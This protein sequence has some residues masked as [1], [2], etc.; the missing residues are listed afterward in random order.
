MANTTSTTS[1]RADI[2]QLKSAM[3]EAARQVKLANSEFKAATAK[4]DDWTK[5]AEGIRAKLKQL[6]TTL[7]AQK[8]QLE[9]YEK[10]LEATTKEYG[11]NSAA[12]DRVRI[13]TNNQKA[14][15]AKTEKQIDQY[16]D[17]LK[18]TEK[19]GDNF[20][21]T[22]DDM[23]DAAKRASDGFSVMKGAL[24]DLVADGIRKAI[25]GFKELY[26]QTI[27]VG[28]SF[29]SSMS[30]VGAISGANKDEL[31]ALTDKAKEMGEKTIF[32]ATESAEAFQYMAMAGWDV[33]DMLNGIEGI[34][35]LAAA[36][37]E[38]LATTSDIVTDALTAMG[39]SAG[40][41]GKLAD[42]MAA[43]SANANTNVGLMGETFQY[44]APIVGALGM[45]ME[46]TAVAVGL[47]ANAGIKG[48]KSGTALR[49]ILTRLSTD[50]GASSESLGALG[51]LTEELGVQFY[52]LDGTVRPLSDILTEARK[53]W[54][55]LSAEQQTSY[56]KTIAGQEAL[57]GWLALMNAADDDVNDLTAAVQNASYDIEDISG[58][59]ETSGVAWEKY[60]ENAWM[61]AG[62]G[63][64]GLADDI[65]Y[66]IEQVGTST[67][68]LKNYLMQE[69]DMNAGDAIKAIESVKTA[70]DDSSGAAER[71]A[72]TM[73][74]N[75]A[76]KMTLLRSKIEGIQI[77]VY[78]KLKPALS[79]AI[80]SFSKVLDSIDWD[81]VANGLAKATKAVLDFA[82]FVITNFTE[83]IEIAKSVG[84]VLLVTFAVN[85]I[86][87]FVSTVAGLI[88]TFK[89]LR[90]VTEG[91]TVAQKALNIAQ[92]ANVIGAITA[93][94][95]GL[96][97]AF[98]LFADTSDEAVQ[99]LDPLTESEKKHVEEVYAMRD[100]YAEVKQRRDEAVE[101]IEAEYN[102][103]QSLADEL[104]DLVDANGKV[105]EGYEDRVNFILTTLNEAVGTEMQLVD[106]VIENYQQEKATLDELIETKKAEA[107]LDA[108]KEAYTE[109]IK[110]RG[111]ALQN[112]IETQNDY[113]EKQKELNDLLDRQSELNNVSVEEYAKQTGA[114]DN[115]KLAEKQLW[116]EKQK[117]NKEIEAT[118]IGI[119]QLHLAT[120]TAEQTFV[121]FNS[122]IKNYEGLSSAIISGDTQKISDALKDM[123]NDFVTAETGTEQSLKN[124][125][126]AFKKKYDE[127]QKAVEEGSAVVTQEMVD[128][129][130]DMVDKSVKELDKFQADAEK[131][132]KQG[133]QKYVDGIESMTGAATQQAQN[134]RT[135]TAKTMGADTSG[136]EQAGKDAGQKYIEGMEGV[137][138]DILTTAEGIGSD[139]VDS[140]NEGQESHSPSAL[141]T[142]SGENFGQ[143]FING[144]D[145]KRG[146]IWEMA[147]SLARRAINALRAGQKEGSPSKLTYQSGVYFVQGYINGIASQQQN[148]QSAIQ[149]MVKGVFNQLKKTEAY[150]FQS[151]GNAAVQ[152]FSDSLTNRLDYTYSK[153]SYQNDKKVQELE[154]ALE[155]LQT[156][157]NTVL[158]AEETALDK[159]IASLEQTRANTL[160]H[161]KDLI[162]DSKTAEF[163]RQVYRN[164]YNQYKE[165][166]DDA[167]EKEKKNG[168]K[169][170]AQLSKQYAKEI[171][172][173]E[174][175][176]E[177]Y[178]TASQSFLAEYQN[179]V[180][181]YK[182]AAVDLIDS[183]INGLADKYNAQYDKL[184][185][186]QNSLVDKLKNAGTLFDVSG[187][188]IMT[189]ND[190]RE[191]TRQITEYTGKLQ[192]IKTKVSAELFDEI[193]SFDMKEGSAY[194]DRLLTMSAKDLTAY[195]KAYT[196]KLKAAEKAGDSIYKTDIA[197]V[198]KSYKN[199]INK[200]FEDMPKQLE[201]L[202]IQA[203]K[204]FVNGL[205][206]NTDYLGKS[207]TTFIKSM[208]DTFKKDL[209]IAS[210]SK[211]MMTIGDYTGEGF[212]EG[213]KATIGQVKKTAGDMIQA[214]ASPLGDVKASV[215]GVRGIVSA[216]TGAAAVNNNTV[217]NYNLVQNNT[218]PKSLSALETYQARRQ[219]IAMMKAFAQ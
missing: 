76:G 104:D 36:S 7:G 8:K 207:V 219:Q 216:G 141:T 160:S 87:T 138:P 201:D 74:D 3:Q 114:T 148:L 125:V 200:A 79:D 66:H 113:I 82:K 11:E 165:Y 173:Q 172:A 164:L 48:Q 22:A 58:A 192:K 102:N 119:G 27:N 31:D 45:N 64:E 88:T 178:K 60:A 101:S 55:G 39:Y 15:I 30:K 120:D 175:I 117:L 21:E 154:K 107:F 124:Q 109:A 163:M 182:N 81:S 84:K 177:A 214:A 38:D 212:V 44:A 180:N 105:K 197:A 161:Y 54:K 70:L 96:A 205:T 186:K 155:K 72:Q 86:A 1:F 40:D 121:N 78:E 147:Y 56:G 149:T 4:M 184:I 94:V 77:Q 18:E 196:E 167:I 131:S 85:K 91:A 128:D 143:G 110:N 99:H 103:Y 122:T 191:Q 2:S 25:S 5:S 211:V 10:E 195:N 218:S 140:L 89:T 202:G 189:V 215:G 159:R 62:K 57:S 135:E 19:A 83:I 63:I 137:K 132:G 166:Y 33:E 187:A 12:A 90:T 95:A 153:M 174:K 181:G 169:Y 59:L 50:A 198:S 24:A 126:E 43:A 23:T 129:M 206:N 108:N 6:D 61:T 170:I 92:S 115:L 152:S 193:A 65:A 16:N 151:V 217:N 171:A 168:E 118:K 9:L 199:E 150:N 139:A 116:V 179:A 37:G 194:I 14:A 75:V 26:K 185:D 52:N 208:L 204:G 49:S 136:F 29:E 98:L 34:M 32:S 190:L 67:E 127:M 47:M 183:T 69:Y 97:S 146:S 162:D 100:A 144:M 213:L 112:Y 46:D 51:T 20:E 42:V 68:D 176:K 80:D 157:Q 106:G 203:M 145:N 188:G 73:N 93:A 156:E 41:A 209:Q 133:M 53:A 13:A 35:N 210:P 111:E 158:N 71:M 28:A 130:R 142:T 123:A 17:E 134:V